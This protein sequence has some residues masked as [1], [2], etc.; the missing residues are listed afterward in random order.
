[1]TVILSVSALVVK[2]F[3][4]LVKINVK[5]FCLLFRKD[6][7]ILKILSVP[8]NIS[9]NSM[10]LH[11]SKYRILLITYPKNFYKLGKPSRK[12]LKKTF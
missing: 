1:M 2:I 11:R 8:V 3:G 12:V 7:V 9:R 5:V 6:L 10:L 4:C